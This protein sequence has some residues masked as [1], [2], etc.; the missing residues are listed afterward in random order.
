MQTRKN[1]FP[2]LKK[3]VLPVVSFCLAPLFYSCYNSPFQPVIQKTGDLEIYAVIANNSLAK[4]SNSLQTICDSLIV[5]ISGSDF[6]TIRS[7]KKVDYSRL[8]VCDTLPQV[9]AGSN[10]TVKIWTSDKEGNVIHTDSLKT[11]T[12]T[13]N[14]GI[15]ASLNVTLIPAAGSIYLQFANVP[16]VV[17]SVFASF[18]SVD[19]AKNWTVHKKRAT[20]LYFSLD[21]IPHLTSGILMAAAV[22]TN[23]DTVYKASRNLIFDALNSSSIDLSFQSVPGGL[24]LSLYAEKPASTLVNISMDNSEIVE[25]GKLVITEIMYSSDD[26]EYVEIYNPDTV[27]FTRDTLVLNLDGTD[28]KLMNVKIRAGSFFVIG[29]KVLPWVD[30]AFSV[31]SALDLSSGGNWITLK[32][33]NGAVIDRVIFTGGTNTLEWP[34]ING[35][36]SIALDKT[37][38][39]VTDNNYGRNWTASQTLIEG[40]SSQYGSPHSF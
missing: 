30:Y 20:K 17:D 40:T 19:S 14:A 18:V 15:P 25:S 1:L 24:Q 27:E 16:T 28:R 21:N 11:R 3:A 13:I 22:N 32:E 35:K 10:R 23:G 26:S 8:V 38:L 36:R 4:S 33:C 6:Q 5:E 9:P 31:S 34:V 2:M 12:V 29:R 7:A 37:A 39:N